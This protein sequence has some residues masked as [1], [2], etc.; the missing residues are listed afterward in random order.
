MTSKEF[1]FKF[2]KSE[3]HVQ[4]HC[5]IGREDPGWRT[6]TQFYEESKRRD[7]H[8]SWQYFVS[9]VNLLADICCGRNGASQEAVSQ[10]V[11]LDVLCSLIEDEAAQQTSSLEVFLKVTTYNV[12][13]IHHHIA[14]PA[15]LRRQ[16]PV[17]ADPAHL[18]RD[19][20]GQARVKHLAHLG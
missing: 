14:S 6:L 10:A 4:I 11:P 15:L 3:S 7:A 19:G 20:V 2:R 13:L 16:L 12:H 5:Y 18:A 9:F 1:Q 17:P 8:Q